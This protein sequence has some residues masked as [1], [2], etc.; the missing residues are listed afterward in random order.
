[1]DWFDGELGGGRDHDV[2]DTGGSW[3]WVTVVILG[4]VVLLAVGFFAV[5]GW[6][7]DLVF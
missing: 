6:L 3:N 7:R 1:M 5:V 2:P 4:V